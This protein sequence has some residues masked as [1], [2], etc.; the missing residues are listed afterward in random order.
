MHSLN[1]FQNRGNFCSKYLV[2]GTSAPDNGLGFKS[3]AKTLSIAATP[4]LLHFPMLLSRATLTFL[5]SSTR[6]PPTRKSKDFA[7]KKKFTLHLLSV[8][9]IH[10][11]LNP[12]EPQLLSHKKIR[13]TAHG[14]S[15]KK[16]PH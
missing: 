15:Q 16:P 12:I 9:I 13:S 4:H 11:H 6:P 7:K 10:S 1:I 2:C 3:P 8:H 5:S 14:G